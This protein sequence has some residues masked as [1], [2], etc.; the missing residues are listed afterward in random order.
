[1]I[2]LTKL[3]GEETL[4]NV[5]QIQTIE[6]IPESKILFVNKEFLLVKEGPDEIIEKIIDFDAK[7][8][9]YHRTLTVERSE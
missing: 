7:I 8:F 5:N 9:G 2:K 3:N 1:M 6:M 4:V